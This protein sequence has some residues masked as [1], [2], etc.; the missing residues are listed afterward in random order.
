MNIQ[1]HEIYMKR[2][3]E[4]AKRAGP[5]VL[6]N[7]NVGAVIV[8]NGRIIGEGYHKKFGGAHAEV[9]A[10]KSVKNN[11]KHLICDATLYVSLEPCNHVGKT[12]ACTNLIIEHKIREVFIGCLDP[13]PQMAGNSLHH[14]QEKGINIHCGILEEEAKGLIAPFSRNI[15]E[16][17][18]FITLKFAQSKDFFISKEN[19]QT[20]LS[21][22][23]S[24]T[25]SHQLRSEANAILI[26]TKT[27]LIDNPEL[28]NRLYPGASPLR[29][30]LDR[31]N[32]LPLTAKL[33]SDEY[34]TLIISEK[35]RKDLKNKLK[36]QWILRFDDSLIE[37]L[38]Q[39]LTLE[40]QIG[41][42]IIEGGAFTINQFIQKNLWDQALVINTQKVLENGIKAP[43][44]HG[45]LIKKITLEDDDVLFIKNNSCT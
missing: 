44:I 1:A 37:R 29:I 20:W 13:N 42:L 9:E 6:T 26:G 22:E 28:T 45:H 34:P 36:E 38:M 12:P 15:S 40:K 11:D 19:E 7:P 41:K 2:C 43:V 32:S 24:K 39:W 18:P 17:R 8:H 14:L 4:L 27:A 31:N 33:L 10:I 35:R 23:L 16:K 25:L 5:N 21:N 3:I 30:V